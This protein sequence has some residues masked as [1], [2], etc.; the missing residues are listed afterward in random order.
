MLARR[1]VGGRRGALAGGALALAGCDD[2]NLPPFLEA[3]ESPQQVAVAEELAIPLIASDPDGDDLDFWVDSPDNVTLIA[4]GRIDESTVVPVYRWVPR[5]SDLGHWTLVLGVDDGTSSVMRTI[6]VETIAS[7][8]GVPVF[9]LPLGGGQ[10]V[11]LQSINRV[12]LDIVV[13]DPD[14]I[15]VDI[16]QEEPIGNSTLTKYGG[17]EAEW[18]WEPS[19][20]Q[21]MESEF[22]LILSADD[23]E[24]PKVFK[25]YVLVISP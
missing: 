19:P 22:R 8:S 15:E 21:A 2:S 14:D 11:D 3:I 17:L 7:A 16:A 10:R 25:E 24:H 23:G 13:E 4:N 1:C 18:L 20:L 6:E 5:A 12:R 9:R